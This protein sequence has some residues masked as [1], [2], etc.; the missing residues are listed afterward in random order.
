MYKVEVIVKTKDESTML[1]DELLKRHFN[2]H[3][4]FNSESI[5]VTEHKFVAVDTKGNGMK[6]QIPL[7]KEELEGCIV[8]ASQEAFDGLV[9]LGIK[10]VEDLENY[11]DH[12]DMGAVLLWVR[13]GVI[14]S[15]NA[16]DYG[17]RYKVTK[18]IYFH[19]G[20]FY[21]D[22][23]QEELDLKAEYKFPKGKFKEDKELLEEFTITEQKEQPHKLEEKELTYGETIKQPFPKSKAGIDWFMITSIDAIAE[24]SITV[25]KGTFFTVF[26]INK[27]MK[28]STDMNFYNLD[29]LKMLHDESNDFTVTWG[30]DEV[31]INAEIKA[32]HEEAL[33]KYDVVKVFQQDTTDSSIWLEESVFLN[34][35][36][37]FESSYI[38]KLHYYNIDWNKLLSWSYANGEFVECEIGENYHFK[39]LLTEYVNNRV[40]VGGSTTPSNLCRIAPNVTIKD[41]WLT[42]VKK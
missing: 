41:E 26:P 24:G 42:E 21:N 16:L 15:F 34:N 36:Y 37:L 8:D 13:K 28:D 9:K 23:Y 29:N 22:Q 18:Q 35:C 32:Q 31:D 3:D 19:K 7:T 14:D 2:T 40:R 38:Y 11:D 5:K 20:N 4:E 1:A 10:V 6:E 27:K 12:T 25:G 17:D 39:G 30:K 33:K